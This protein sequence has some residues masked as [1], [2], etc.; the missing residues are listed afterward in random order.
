M[1][2]LKSFRN[3]NLNQAA[4]ARNFTHI[5]HS[6]RVVKVPEG[7]PIFPLKNQYDFD[8]GVGDIAGLNRALYMHRKI[9]EADKI[10]VISDD[11]KLV[12]DGEL[13]IQPLIRE[14][15]ISGQPVDGAIGFRVNKAKRR[16]LV[17]CLGSEIR[18]GS[19][20]PV[21]QV[22]TKDWKKLSREEKKE[23]HKTHEPERDLAARYGFT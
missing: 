2:D 5:A 4:P 6:T 18:Q 22:S 12:D 10:E 7:N 16:V 14:T 13:D 20:R 15:D 11:A 17:D 21:G 23:L 1:A 3:V 8:N 9:P 19:S